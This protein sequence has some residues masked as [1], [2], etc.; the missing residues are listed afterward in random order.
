VAERR[1]VTRTGD[2]RRKAEDWSRRVDELLASLPKPA[3][4]KESP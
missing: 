4:P 1:V 3:E 2:R